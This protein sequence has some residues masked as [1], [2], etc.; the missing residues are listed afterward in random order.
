MRIFLASL[1]NGF[2]AN[3][4]NLCLQYKPKYLLESF[5]YKS[6]CERILKIIDKNNFLLDS[7]AFTF[8]SGAKIT[9]AE[10]SVYVNNYI[11]FINKHDLKYFVEVDVES[12]FGMEQVEEWRKHI[13]KNT[14]KK[15]I[16]VWHINRGIQYWKDMVQDYKYIAIGG[17]VQKIFN[18]NK[19]DYNNFKK[20]I[21]Y[22]REKGVKVHGLGFTRTKEISE[23]EYY[24]VDSSTWKMGAILGRQ[25]HTFNGKKITVR[26]LENNKK[27]N[28]QKIIQHNFIEWCKYQYYMEA[29]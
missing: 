7:G 8:M 10:M 16:P 25:I 22:A 11:D 3:M 19:T 15:V 9:K 17:Q 20:M 13:E 27:A 12:I 18:L 23:Y 24:S 29:V 4:E 6:H 28:F 5:F 26:R 2:T 14:G 1:F 21:H